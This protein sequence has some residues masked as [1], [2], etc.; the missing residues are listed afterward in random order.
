[1]P[2]PGQFDVRETEG[3]RPS[4]V[5]AI[6]GGSFNPPH[7]SHVLAAAYVLACSE[8]DRLLVVPA[9]QHP[10]AKAL[11]S[12]SHRLAMCRL[13]FADLGRVSVSSVEE[14]LGGESI[15]VR[16]LEHLQA[17]HPGWSMRLVVG[18]DVVHEMARWT[19]PERVRA[20][21]PAIILG[22]VGVVLPPEFS[23]VA[24]VLPEVSS[25]QIRKA[26]G[27]ATTPVDAML[28]LSVARYIR[29]HGLYR[30]NPTPAAI[31]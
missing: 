2:R 29:T 12:F 18:A 21:A 28:P 16:T 23:G 8:V 13:A 26:I 31:R 4:E 30:S 15:T 11:T 9:F 25:S 19:Q 3:D 27:E 10:F 20:L 5:V 6:F 17:S 1:M 7:V 24:N 14:D 22:R